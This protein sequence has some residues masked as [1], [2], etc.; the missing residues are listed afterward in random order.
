MACGEILYGGQENAC[1]NNGIVQIIGE[2][3]ES[4]LHNF[5]INTG[6]VNHNISK[7]IWGITDTSA[8]PEWATT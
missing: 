6:R 3:P 5:L 2:R 1:E 4:G 7:V 8:T